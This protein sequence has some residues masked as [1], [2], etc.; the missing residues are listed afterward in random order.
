MGKYV[1]VSFLLCLSYGPTSS[2]QGLNSQTIGSCLILKLRGNP[3]NGPVIDFCAHSSV[4]ANTPSNTE[5]LY[6][7]VGPQI[8]YAFDQ[9]ERAQ[10]GYVGCLGDVTVTVAIFPQLLANAA[11]VRNQNDLGILFNTQLVDFIDAAARSF[12][13]DAL[14]ITSH[15]PAQGGY[16]DWMT[17][18]ENLGGHA[19]AYSVPAPATTNVSQQDMLSEWAY[20]SAAYQFILAHELSHLLTP[21]YQCRYSGSDSLGIEKACDAIA[22]DKLLRAPQTTFMPV[23]PVGFMMA[24]ESYERLTGPLYRNRLLY[25]GAPTTFQEMFPARDWKSR[26]QQMTQQWAA[27][28]ATG[29]STPICPNGYQEVVKLANSM[30]TVAL[31]DPCIEGNP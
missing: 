13:S 23:V 21:N 19:C 5:T 18:M 7:W 25:A 28:C 30:T 11:V 16:A 17:A 4:A 24:M 2:A 1:L 15:Q 10:C 6:G 12:C 27:F 29:A 8:G 26:A 9:A 20:A 22:T 14:K 31:P 3:T